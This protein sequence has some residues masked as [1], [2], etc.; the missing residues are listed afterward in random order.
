MS[1]RLYATATAFQ[2]LLDTLRE[3]ANKYVTPE[4]GIVEDTDTIEGFRYL[5]HLMSVGIDFYLEGDPERPEFRKMTS[6]TR[7]YGGDNPD[8]IYHF[9]QIRGD[10]SYRI[11]GKKGEECY[12][13]FTVHGRTDDGKLGM[14]AEPVLADV[15]DRGLTIAPDGSFEVILSPNEHPGNWIKLEPNAACVITRHYFES[16]YSVGADAN[17]EVKL[18][19]EPLDAPSARPPL[20]DEALGRR[21]DDIA[22]FVRGGTVE[23]PALFDTQLPFVSATPN[24]LPQPAVFR[25]SGQSGWGAVDIAYAMGLFRVRLDQALVI[26]GTFPE[27]A[28]VNVVL[29]NRHMQTFEFRDRQVSLNRKQI[30]LEPDGSY[31]IVIAHRDPGVPNWLD[32]EGHTEGIIFWR[33][34]L[35]AVTRE[36]PRCTV[37]PF[38]EVAR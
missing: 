7:K 3:A 23:L 1:E 10:R 5:L 33:F 8:A 27:C 36:K 24:E 31:R 28:F 16:K 13:S 11:A 35:P 4:R 25:A 9:A 21:I 34:L 17:T 18:R 30:V 6:P 14:A 26:E 2:G 12:L 22:A 32:T 20:S 19:V 38:S 29:W 37:V 15:N